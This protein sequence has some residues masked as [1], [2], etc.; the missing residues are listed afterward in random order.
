MNEQTRVEWKRRADTEPGYAIALALLDYGTSASRET[1]RALDTFTQ[2]YVEAMF[3][4]STGTGD[5]GDLE[6]ASF[7]QLAPSALAEIKED[8]AEFQKAHRAMLDA[9]GGDDSQHGHDFWLT[10]NHHGAGFWDRG[11]GQ[12][13]E[14]LTKWSHAM[15]TVDMYRGDDGLIYLA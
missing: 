7:D 15:G 4:T 12:L 5:D 6:D 3:F 1:F 2:A 14:E 13:G 10:R 9:T 8:C 11:Y